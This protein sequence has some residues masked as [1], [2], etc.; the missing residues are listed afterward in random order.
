MSS[1]R[2]RFSATKSNFQISAVALSTRL[3]RF[4]AVVLSRTA[5]NGRSTSSM[6][7]LSPDS[8]TASPVH[9]YRL[10]AVSP[11]PPRSRRY[12]LD[13]DTPVHA[14][15][16]VFGPGGLN[17]DSGPDSSFQPERPAAAGSVLEPGGRCSRI[18]LGFGWPV[19][20]RRRSSGGQQHKHAGRPT[21]ATESG[22]LAPIGAEKSA[23]TGSARSF[24]GLWAAAF[25]FGDYT[26]DLTNG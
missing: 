4:A 17:G 26:S 12:P 1:L 3:N 20:H 25:S 9:R 7:E 13:M 21:P 18:C 24:Q 19:P 22:G 16:A 8:A 23:L 15:L 14:P 2:N 5:A 11:R 10:S 6:R